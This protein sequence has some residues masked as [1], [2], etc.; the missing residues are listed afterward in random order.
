MDFLFVVV[1]VDVVVAGFDD[2]FFVASL[3]SSWWRRFLPRDAD[4]PDGSSLSSRLLTLVEAAAGRV[5]T[6]DAN[7]D[8]RFDSI[9]AGKL[10]VIIVVL[11]KLFF[12]FILK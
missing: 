12:L 8:D 10:L 3:D 6:F 5:S 1:V 4:D 7:D 9:L 11:F 2:D